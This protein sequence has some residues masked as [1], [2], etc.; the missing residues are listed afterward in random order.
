MTMLATP[1]VETR[2]ANDPGPAPAPSYSLFGTLLITLPPAALTLVMTVVGIGTRSLWNDEYATWYVATLNFEDFRRLIGNVDAVIAP[3]YLL[4]HAWV[5]VF[6][7]SAASLRMPSA[8]AMAAASA[9]IALVGRRLFD[10]GVAV[11]A[12]LLFAGLPAV[13][14][15]GQEARPYSFAIAL[16]VLATLVMLRAIERP[17]WRNWVLYGVVLIAGGCT[18]IVTLTVLVPHALFMWFT[19]R[20]RGDFR[21]L[22]WIAGAV[23]AITGILPLAAVGSQQSSAI[24]WIRLNGTAIGQLPERLFGAGIVAALV[25]GAALLAAVL[26]WPRHRSTVVLLGAWALVPPLFCL[27]T[28]P[29]LHLFL[30]RYLLFTLPAW[31]LLAAAV[32]FP[33]VRSAARTFG[34]LSLA[35]LLVVAGVFYLGIPGQAEARHSPVAGEPDFRSAARSVESRQVPGDGIA[36]A[37]AGRNGRR[38]FHFETRLSAVEP[39]DVLI[40]KTSQQ[41]GQFGPADCADPGRCVGDTKRIWL[42]TAT[43]TY[44][45]PLTGMTETIQAYLN[46]AFTL[47][48]IQSFPNVRIFLLNRKAG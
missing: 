14:R 47:T 4:M 34:A 48:E 21:L 41:I 28:F 33:F 32:G 22:R 29:V 31:V 13:S 35:G 12:G 9:L 3:Y 16:A 42:I 20:A 26:L 18:H 37:G 40:A 2:A 10:P 7:E 8:L 5:A 24:D 11:T 30:H 15:Y 43:G 36:F 46:S 1:P 23:I 17:R 27:V 6:G 44:Q 25:T 45:D 39:A 19:F 38:A